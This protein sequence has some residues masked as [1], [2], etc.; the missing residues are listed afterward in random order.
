MKYRPGDVVS[1]RKGLVMHRGVVLSDGN[2]LHNSPF[3]GEHVVSEA[4]FREGKR[5][6]VSRT[7]CPRQRR[8]AASARPEDGGSYNLFT[9]NCEHT[10][11]RA[12]TGEGSSPQLKSWVAGIGVGAVAFALTR[13]PAITAAGYA[14]GRKLG[15]KL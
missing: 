10:V 11:S 13:H 14:L 15:G 1:R 2:I 9:N 12:M 5:L 3:R 8:F 7:E 6:H 4:E